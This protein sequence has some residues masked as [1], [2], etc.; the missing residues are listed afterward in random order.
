[1]TVLW[2]VGINAYVINNWKG[3]INT[4]HCVQVLKQYYA[5]EDIFQH[6]ESDK[7]K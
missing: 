6:E 2:G 1:M 3:T 7:N 5:F 4:G